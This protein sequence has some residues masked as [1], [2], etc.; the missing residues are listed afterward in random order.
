MTGTYQRLGV[1]GQPISTFRYRVEKV[2]ERSISY[3]LDCG[4][5]L[6]ALSVL[7]DEASRDLKSAVGEFTG[8]VRT[9][10][11]DEGEVRKFFYSSYV[12]CGL[13]HD[14]SLFNDIFLGGL[15]MLMEE[16]TSYQYIVNR[17]R[18]EASKQTLLRLAAKR[19][20]VLSPEQIA[21][22]QS[23]YDLSKHE[24]LLDRILIAANWD[25]FLKDI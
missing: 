13:R 1:G 14:V 4:P 8:F 16:S 12:L 20:G 9:R 5:G 23:V 3:W 15:N 11:A 24:T 25:E 22:F 18:T 10:V 6:A 2:W 17:V 19:F 7:T 21:Q